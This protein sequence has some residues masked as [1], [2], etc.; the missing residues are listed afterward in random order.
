[1]A[2]AKELSQGMRVAPLVSY[3]ETVSVSAQDRKEFRSLLEEAIAFDVD[4]APDMRVANLISQRRA[5]WLLSRIDELF[6]E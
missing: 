2:R 5:K 4:K 1:M 6:V 3:A